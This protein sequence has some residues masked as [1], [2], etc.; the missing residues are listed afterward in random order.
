M[1]K[2][3]KKEKHEEDNMWNKSYTKLATIG[4]GTYGTVYKAQNNQTKELLAIKKIKLEVDTEGVPS[5]ALREIVILKKMDHQ[6]I[7]KL[8][9]IECGENKLFLFFEFLPYDLR[10]YINE[11]Y[12]EK[13]NYIPILQIKMIMY[14]LLLGTRHLHSNKVLHRDLKPQNI[15]ID[16]TCQVKIADF[17][18][19]RIYTIPIRPYTKEVCKKFF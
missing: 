9:N 8:I 6:N 3:E 15:L 16:D 7:V 4:S 11:K 18:L 1:I 17:G 2:T 14:Q 13:E 12:K 19:S 10:K 5:T